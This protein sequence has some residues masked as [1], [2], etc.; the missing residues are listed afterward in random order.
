MSRVKRIK[1]SQ[2]ALDALG[3]LTLKELFDVE[4]I[5]ITISR[6]AHGRPMAMGMFLG[7]VHMH[8]QIIER[9]MRQQK[10]EQEQQSVSH[11]RLV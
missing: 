4:D 3:S 1:F 9:E 2:D 8:A 7:G 5:L 11:L 10:H 6:V